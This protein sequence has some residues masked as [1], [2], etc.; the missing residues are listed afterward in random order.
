MFCSGGGHGRRESIQ[1]HN[2]DTLR[3]RTVLL[4]MARLP[5]THPQRHTER[6]R[7]LQVTYLGLLPYILTCT[8]DVLRMNEKLPHAHG[9][10]ATGD[11]TE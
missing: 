6:L 11:P 10:W 5:V 3:R 8:G 2:S 1:L 7:H 9:R 4:G